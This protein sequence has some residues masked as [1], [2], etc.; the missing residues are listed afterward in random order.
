MT[1]VAEAASRVSGGDL[2]TRLRETEDPDLAPLVG[3][4]N[5]MVDTLDA[6]IEQDARFAADVAHELR[7]PV[8]TLTTSLSLLQKATDLSPRSEQA[9]ALMSV[10]LRRFTR[11]LEDLL[12]L[13]RLDH[14]TREGANA[15]VGAADLVREA[16][17]SSGRDPAL[18]AV[19]G[20]AAEAVRVTADAPQLRRALA[21]LFD[22][23]DIHGGG[24][25]RCR[26]VTHGEVVDVQVEDHGPGIPSEDRERVFERFARAGSRKDGTGSGL[27]LSIVAQTVRNHGGSVWCSAADGGGALVT[28]RLPRAGEEQ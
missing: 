10:E 26:V 9:V 25:V 6:R 20:V 16:L 27:G 17:G 19:G 22:N 5:N 18:L 13:G 7:T 15:T 2:S 21:N 12:A 8:T 24:L 28:L 11:A 3:A 14:A 23:A 1:D 4:F